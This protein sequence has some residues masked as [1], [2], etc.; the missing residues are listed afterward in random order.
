MSLASK[1]FGKK[2]PAASAKKD[3]PVITLT[4]SV[5]EGAVR[6]KGIVDD[7]KRLQ[8]DEVSIKDDISNVARDWFFENPTKDGAV[9]TQIELRAQIGDTVVDCGSAQVK[10]TKYAVKIGN[11][12]AEAVKSTLVSAVGGEETFDRLFNIN[13]SLIIS[14]SKIPV[15]KQ[16]VFADRLVALCE[17]LGLDPSE[18]VTLDQTVNP[19]SEYNIE[20]TKLPPTVLRTLEGYSKTQVAVI[21]GEVSVKPVEAVA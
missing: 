8:A 1:N 20:K 2:V 18:V 15:D 6:L 9:V 5:A 19:K 21:P 13:Q 11:Q 16:G 14:A 7:V 4:G 12:D 10:S 3:R 17:E